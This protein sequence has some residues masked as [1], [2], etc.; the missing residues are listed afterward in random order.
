M[1]KKIKGILHNMLI[2][3]LVS[4]EPICPKREQPESTNSETRS[5]GPLRSD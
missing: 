5:G 2:A 1:T 4:W 3:E